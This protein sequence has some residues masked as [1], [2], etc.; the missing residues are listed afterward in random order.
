MKLVRRTLWNIQIVST[1]LPSPIPAPVALFFDLLFPVPDA[2]TRVGR[3][4]LAELDHDALG[5]VLFDV[6]AKGIVVLLVTRRSS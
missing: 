6:R 2:S 1:E 5:C 3:A 4:L